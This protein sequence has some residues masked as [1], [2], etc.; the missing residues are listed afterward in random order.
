[1]RAIGH[2]HQTE[3]WRLFIDSNKVSLKAILFHSGN[4]YPSLLVAH[5]TSTKE[6]F[7]VMQLSLD[8]IDYKLH[9]W[10]IYGDSKVIRILRELQS[11][12]SK[13]SCFLRTWDGRARYQHYDVNVWLPRKTLKPGKLNV[14]QKSLVDP[15]KIFLPG[16]HIKMSIV[17]H[18]I[19]TL[20][21]NR[22]AF[23]FSL[24]NKFPQLREAKIR[25]GV[26]DGPQIRQLMLDCD[27]EKSLT[28]LKRRTWTST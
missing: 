20:N 23:L 13:Y 22:E 28:E 5:A 1:M 24:K 2:E 11:G 14:S 4:E 19:K 10:F 16:L 26:F 3:N 8:K 6:C 15:Q 27:F 17:K 18:F 7:D 21:K 9:K 12:Y 25:E